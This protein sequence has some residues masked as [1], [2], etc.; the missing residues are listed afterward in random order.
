MARLIDFTF[1]AEPSTMAVCRGIIAAGL[2]LYVLGRWL[3]VAMP[4]VCLLVLGYGAL[5]NSQGA[6][7]H[8]LQIVGIVL[9]V[10]TVYYL[11]RA[12]TGR[13]K[14][15][16]SSRE[17]RLEAHAMAVW[18]SMQAVVATYVVTAV[19]KLV[20]SELGWLRKAKHFPLQLEKSQKSEYYNT[21]G[22]PMNHSVR[23]ATTP[24]NQPSPA[25]RA[26]SV[27]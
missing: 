11:W 6:A 14:I 20:R 5:K 21:L 16:P 12:V 27:L 7:T 18:L 8:S 17:R 23:L 15:D 10:Q 4:P 26:S 25:S 2:I 9:L 24:S 19:T 3:L 1:M 13:S 22:A